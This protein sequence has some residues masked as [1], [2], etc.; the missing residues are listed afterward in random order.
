MISTKA[1]II[2]FPHFSKPIKFKTLMSTKMS[3]QSDYLDRSGKKLKIIC[4]L[5]FKNLPYLKSLMWKRMKLV[6]FALQYIRL[7]SLTSLMWTKTWNW[8]G[9]RCN[10]LFY[11]RRQPWCGQKREISWVCVS[12]YEIKNTLETWKGLEPEIW[13]DIQIYF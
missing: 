11:L 12:S 1:L 3:K 9:L 4:L 13:T 8:L 7:P 5:Q 10:T 2:S 6:V